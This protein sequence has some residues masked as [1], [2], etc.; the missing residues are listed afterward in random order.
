MG[1]G[2]RFST[3]VSVGDDP[4]R[5]SLAALLAAE[6]FATDEDL[7]EQARSRL[8]IVVEE[9]VS[10]AARH[11]A[12]SGAIT[13]ELTMRALEGE[14]ALLL[15]DNGRAFDPTAKRTFS[16]PDAETGGG[17]GLALVRAWA[18]AFRYTREGDRNRIELVL[19]IS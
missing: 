11:G 12:R 9:L 13:I 4:A 1:A 8:A 5:V 6:D 7:G 2:K 18:R 16:G 14:V 3:R 10:N 17:V 15:E 19:G